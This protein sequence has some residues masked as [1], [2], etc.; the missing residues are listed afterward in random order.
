MVS[1]APK[2]RVP[3]ICGSGLVWGYVV[4]WRV[5]L[6]EAL[7]EPSRGPHVRGI[8]R[9]MWCRGNPLLAKKVRYPRA[10]PNMFQSASRAWRAKAFIFVELQT[11]SPSCQEVYWCIPL[12]EHNI[13][14]K[15]HR[16]LQFEKEVL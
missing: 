13:E 1:L 7:R 11:Q 8:H 4:P 5:R 15:V 16:D 9:Y 10:S 12:R 6:F 2:L 14:V 3:A